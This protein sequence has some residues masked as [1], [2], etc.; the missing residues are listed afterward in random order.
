MA[1]KKRKIL[2]T[3]K[4][5]AKKVERKKGNTQHNKKFCFLV[6]FFFVKKTAQKFL[7]DNEITV[8]K[9]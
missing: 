3:E 1:Y 8:N 6:A 2:N 5:R 7:K 4:F 9:Y